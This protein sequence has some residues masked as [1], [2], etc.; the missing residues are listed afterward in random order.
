VKEMCTI[1]DDID[2]FNENWKWNLYW[3][4]A[5]KKIKNIL[6]MEYSSNKEEILNLIF[7]LTEFN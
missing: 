4:E 7:D 5:N 6:E 3:N 1:I 2:G